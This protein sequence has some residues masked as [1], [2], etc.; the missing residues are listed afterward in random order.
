[1]IFRR[2][3]LAGAVG[4]FEAAVRTQDPQ[5]TEDA[6]GRL[7]QRAA[8]ASRTELTAAAVRLAG[9]L[10]EVPTAPRARVALFPARLGLGEGVP[11][12]GHQQVRDHRGEP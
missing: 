6:L 9:L 7:H 4:R 11:Q 2:A 3:R 12:F 10:P 8:C 5:A 1:M